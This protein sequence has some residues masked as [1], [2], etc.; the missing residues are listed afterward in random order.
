MRTRIALAGALLGTA[1]VVGPLATAAHGAGPAAVRCPS[2]VRAE[3]CDLLDQA[4]A[5]IQPLQVV[6]APAG[7]DLGIVSLPSLAA[8]PEGVPTAVVLS[9]VTSV[10]DQIADLPA[11][12]QSTPGLVQLVDSLDALVGALTAPVG[13][14]VAPASPERPTPAAP[15]PAPASRSTAYGGTETS[16]AS[17]SAPVDS[18]AIP[19]VPVGDSLTL[20]PLSLPDFGFDQGFDEPAPAVASATPATGAGTA[21][22]AY[23]TAADRLQQGSTGPEVLVTVAAV[24]LLLGAAVALDARKRAPVPAD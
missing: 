7:A 6:L 18:P 2:S 23:Q 13:D 15:T 17:P 1:A 14:E 12:L 11:P 24:V 20:A 22:L 5:Q 9:R 19:D 4:A 10:R 21:E 3:V 8:R 16:A